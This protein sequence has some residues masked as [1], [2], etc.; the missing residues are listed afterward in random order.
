MIFLSRTIAALA[1]AGAAF[2]FGV[3]IGE[4][5]ELG[6]LQ[7]VFM[8]VIPLATAALAFTV[9]S[10]RAEVMLTG[11]VMFAGLQYG[12][13][14]FA[15]AWD[16]CRAQAASLRASIAEY[17]A[18]TGDYPSRLR[19]LGKPPC[20]CFLRRT[21]LHYNASERGYRAWMTNDR[22]VVVI[23]SERSSDR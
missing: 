12:R 11:L 8:Y 5:G 10:G 6:V 2:L 20:G 16:S 9:K 7:D 19:D 22:E 13:Y 4:R 21:I 23:A 17:R 18:R 15:I 14:R 3:A 1:Y